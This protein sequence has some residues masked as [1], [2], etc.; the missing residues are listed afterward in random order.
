ME[1][2]FQLLDVEPEIKDARDALQVS[3]EGGRRG[4]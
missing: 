1:K 3:E 4:R 2:M